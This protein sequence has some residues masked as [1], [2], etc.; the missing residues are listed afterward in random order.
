MAYKGHFSTWKPVEQRE[1][2]DRRHMGALS[3][4]SSTGYF[5]AIFRALMSKRAP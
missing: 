1:A 2:P 4:L 3:V 5:A